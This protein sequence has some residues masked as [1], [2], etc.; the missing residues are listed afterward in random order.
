MYPGGPANWR[1]GADVLDAEQSR[2]LREAAG[3]GSGV[4]PRQPGPGDAELPTALEK[5]GRV[6]Q[7]KPA[8]VTG[9]SPTT[10]AR[11]SAQLRAGGAL[12]SDIEVDAGLFG[13][14]AR[15]LL[16]MSVRPA[17]LEPVATALSTPVRPDPRGSRGRPSQ[18]GPRERGFLPSV[19]PSSVT[20]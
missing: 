3:S 2:V 7:G 16:W 9:R 10:V 4:M 15:A 8:R 1:R 19:T 13:V 14:N 17:D 12:L 5:D 18:A 6:G 20:P 11:R